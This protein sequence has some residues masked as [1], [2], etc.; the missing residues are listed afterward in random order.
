ME[1][2][3]IAA[4]AQTAPEQAT[5][6]LAPFGASPPDMPQAHPFAEAYD[7]DESTIP[8]MAE[9]IKKY[10]Q[11]IACVIY[12]EQL[13]DGRRR[14]RACL[15]AG[16]VPKIEV[17]NGDDEGALALVESLNSRRR[18]DSKE[19]IEKTIKKLYA[20]HEEIAARRMGAGV[21]ADPATK[22]RA[23]DAVANAVGGAVSGRTVQRIVAKSH[24]IHGHPRANCPECCKHGKVKH[25]CIDCRD[26]VPSIGTKQRE[27]PGTESDEAKVKKAAAMAKAQD[28]ARDRI[29]TAVIEF[30][31]RPNHIWYALG[32]EEF[33]GQS[34]RIIQPL[35]SAR[36]CAMGKDDMIALE[37]RNLYSNQKPIIR[38]DGGV[39]TTFWISGRELKALVEK[40]EK[41]APEAA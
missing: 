19:Q 24:C 31:Q 13:L 36:W 4:V 8:E 37:M 15:A 38:K 25:T 33:D 17:Y 16:V 6:T 10:G 35:I 28:E 39:Q 23:A 7:L 21:P 5:G 1:Q 30:E 40:L 11:R 20:F 27:L 9:D 29:T 26:K 3:E 14:W 12:K 22:G 18:M 2:Q 34:K 32:K 41:P